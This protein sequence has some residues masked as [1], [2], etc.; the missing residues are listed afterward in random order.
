MNGD[1]AAQN[2]MERYN[3]QDVNLL[4]KLYKVLLPWIP[5]HP[6]H[7][8]WMKPGK[9]VC[10]NC[11]SRKLQ[12]RGIERTKTLKYQRYHCQSCGKWPRSRLSISTPE[13]KE[14]VLVG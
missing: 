7:A 6:N 12:K 14:G 1:T 5:N 13:D 8:L 2:L 3:R 11:G 4:E 10:P 9:P